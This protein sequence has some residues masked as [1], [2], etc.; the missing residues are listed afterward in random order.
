MQQFYHN[1]KS[2]NYRPYLRQLPGLRVLQ[3]NKLTRLRG[4]YLWELF[5]RFSSEQ[6]CVASGAALKNIQRD[7]GCLG[8]VFDSHEVKVWS[9]QWIFH[10]RIKGTANQQ[11]A[12]VRSQ[13]LRFIYRKLLKA[14]ENNKVAR[15]SLKKSGNGSSQLYEYTPKSGLPTVIG[16]CAQYLADLLYLLCHQR[17]LVLA[18]L[19]RRPVA[20]SHFYLLWRLPATC[21]TAGETRYCNFQDSDAVCSNTCLCLSALGHSLRLG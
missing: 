5:G 15:R 1:R 19:R 12:C 11:I 8:F 9:L 18:P 3:K 14:I 2:E 10:R 13:P 17:S 16:G 7:N 20:P 6:R 4:R 21:W